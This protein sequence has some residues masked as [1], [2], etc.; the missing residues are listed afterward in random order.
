MPVVGYETRYLVSS[1]G[2]VRSIIEMNNCDRNGVFLVSQFKKGRYITCRLW[3][4]GKGSTQLVH[5]LVAKAF[6]ANPDKYLE[7]NHKD[8]DKHN[9]HYTNLEWCNRRQNEDHAMLMDIKYRARGSLNGH[10]LVNED[11]VR[12]MRK[13]WSAGESLDSLGDYYGMR[14]ISI[15]NIVKKLRWKHVS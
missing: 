7:I 10:A 1:H 2:R 8:T 14:P 13:R 11:Q 12:E 5:R 3:E 15:Y 6:I 9:N 4:Y